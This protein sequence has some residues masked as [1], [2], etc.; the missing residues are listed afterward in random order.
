MLTRLS[1]VTCFA[2]E[3][4]GEQDVVL[5]GGS[6]LTLRA[7]GTLP[8][9]PLI[10]RELDCRG[11]LA[12][13]GFVDQHVHFAGGGGDLGFQSRTPPLTAPALFGA[14]ITTAVGLLGADGLT[15]SPAELLAQ[16]KRL[17]A[18]GLTTYMYSGSY[19]L[20]PVTVTGSLLRDMVVV[21]QVLGAGEVAI[22]DSRAPILSVTEL[23][24][25]AS[26]VSLGGLLASKAGVVHL[27]V[28]DGKEGLKVLLQA[29]E[30]SDLPWEMF[31]PTHVNRNPALF[32]EAIRYN[33]SGG[34]I[35]LTAGERTGIS[36]PEAVRLLKAAGAEL[37]RVTVSSDAGGSIP[38][39]GEGTPQALFQDFIEIRQGG[40][41]SPEETAWLFAGNPARGLGLYPRKGALQEGS[42][43]DL[44]LV[45]E[46][47]R[48][49]M[50]FASGRLVLDRRG[51]GDDIGENHG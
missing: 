7:P 11:L 28:G 5:S 36:V 44:L 21:D 23:L 10:E 39:G 22:S 48:L 32:E 19:T 33:K 51:T 38:G 42:D 47:G 1:G 12:F 43:A 35:D 18:D 41:L 40:H 9:H 46:K 14:G 49:T 45:D 30:A 27:H 31:I 16:A 17:A 25:L 20:P 37:S 4:L 29:L 6:L 26:E 15:R 34:R 50:V 3:P 13:P 24:K 8:R 2:P